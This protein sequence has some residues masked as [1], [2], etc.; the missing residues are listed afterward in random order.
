[1][2]TWTSDEL[3]KIGEAE[4]L[5]FQSLRRDG[6][7]RNSVIVWVVRVRD[8]LY[9]RCIN[10]RAGAWFRGIQTQH[11]G[12]ILAGGVQKEVTFVDENDPAINE[13]VD[14]AYRPKYRRY[15]KSYVD[16]CLTIQA[17]ASTIKLV[18]R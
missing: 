14:A 3:D 13:L 4:E 1:M 15:P 9:I 11:A 6:T 7:L 10:G 2:T 12:R 5:Q 17:R 18:P 8:G 16:A